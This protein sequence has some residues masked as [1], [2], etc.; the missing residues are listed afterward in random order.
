MFHKYSNIDISQGCLG[1]GPGDHNQLFML[2]FATPIFEVLSRQPT[3]K[4]W[5]PLTAL[6]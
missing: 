5:R 1:E 3:V 6:T 4:T 2:G